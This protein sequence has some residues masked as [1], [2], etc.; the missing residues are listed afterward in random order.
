MGFFVLSLFFLFLRTENSFEKYKPNR[1]APS[2][3]SLTPSEVCIKSVSNS[4]QNELMN[5]SNKGKRSKI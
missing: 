5:C 1:P 3:F 2:L 4:F